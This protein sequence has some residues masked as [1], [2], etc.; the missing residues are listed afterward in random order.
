MANTDL[1]FYGGL[2]S[3]LGFMGGGGYFQPWQLRGQAQQAQALSGY[4]PFTTSGFLRQY[5]PEL[6]GFGQYQ[7]PSSLREAYQTFRGSEGAGTAAGL[8]EFTQGL[9]GREDV[10][11]LLHQSEL[12]QE[13]AFLTGGEGGALGLSEAVRKLFGQEGSAI[14][15]LY[16]AFGE[17]TAIEDIQRLFGGGARSAVGRL[18]ASRQLGS[19]VATQALRQATAAQLLRGAGGP[20]DVGGGQVF[21][22]FSRDL[23]TDEYQ[24]GRAALGGNEALAFGGRLVAEQNLDIGRDIGQYFQRA[25]EGGGVGSVF[26]KDGGQ[27]V[28]QKLA[29]LGN[30]Q[31]GQAIRGGALSPYLSQWISGNIG[32]SRLGQFQRAFAGGLYTT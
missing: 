11:G 17:E 24:L 7:L 2:A 31:E 8:R 32:G 16:G 10:Q 25:V 15:Q 29:Q 20:I 18:A 19:G 4:L 12:Q 6:G 13:G 21:N 5:A 14:Q 26:S 28:T 3:Q 30:L 22:P 27:Y 23:L 9:Y 1:G